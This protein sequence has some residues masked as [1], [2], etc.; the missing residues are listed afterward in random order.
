MSPGRSF[1]NASE[2]GHVVG[3]LAT[4]VLVDVT[5]RAPCSI[6]EVGEV[7]L[8]TLQARL[9]LH[10][11]A[12]G[13]VLRERQVEEVVRPLAGV[14]AHQVGRHVVG[15][16]EHRVEVERAA[17]GERRDLVERHEGAPQHHRVAQVVEAAPAG[18][19]GELGVLPWREKRVMV[20]GELAELLDDDG[21]GRHVDADRQRLGGED[22]LHQAFD[23]ARLNRL[24]ERGHH[25]RVVRGDAGFQLHEELGVAQHR[26]IGGIDAAEACLDDVADAF[27]IGG[28]GEVHAGSDH[29]ARCLVA[30][31]ATE[32]EADGRQHPVPLE[33]LDHF[34]PRW[35]EQAPS[36]LLLV[37]LAVATAARGFRIEA[38]RV[39]VGAAVHQHR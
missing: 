10:H 35:C 9:D 32:D 23:E 1:I 38:H 31:V 25:A 12:I 19:A 36:A 21:L 39:V 27:A 4:P 22:H 8:A 13:L 11:V 29:A 14:R 5:E 6:Q 33:R 34:E 17:A 30:L 3:T 26:Q 28:A 15:G 18:A 7:L 16:P 20:A 24:L 37:A 2:I